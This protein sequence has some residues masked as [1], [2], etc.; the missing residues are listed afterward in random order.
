M[1]NTTSG[2][3]IFDKDFSIDDI[4]EE[5]YERLELGAELGVIREHELRA[6]RSVDGGNQRFTDALDF[7]Y[8]KSV[9]EVWTKWDHDDFQL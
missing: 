3:T 4:V 8:S 1:A 7:G 2:T 5:A 9:D 6:A